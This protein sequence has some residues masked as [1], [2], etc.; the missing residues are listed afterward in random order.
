[1]D[2]Y[3]IGLLN[4]LSSGNSICENIHY[5]L[6]NVLA[7]AKPETTSTKLLIFA[8]FNTLIINNLLLLPTLPKNNYNNS[9]SSSKWSVSYI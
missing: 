3:I 5:A 7:N 4:I 1:M 2:K 6:R 8:V 9:Y